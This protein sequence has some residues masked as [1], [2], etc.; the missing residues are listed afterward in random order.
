MAL[1]LPNPVFLR[2][3]QMQDE[4]RG[5]AKLKSPH[6]P[7]GDL[8]RPAL[9][10]RTGQLPLVLR[11]ESSSIIRSVRC[12]HAHV[13]VALGR[14]GVGQKNYCEVSESEITPEMKILTAAVEV[15]LDKR[16]G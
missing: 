16:D 14:R 1:S 12:S 3:S 7:E 6:F 11:Q 4:Q 13:L 5:C 8:T 2:S 10:R 15:E 9:L